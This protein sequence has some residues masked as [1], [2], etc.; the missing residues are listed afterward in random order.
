M[1]EYLTAVWNSYQ[2]SVDQLESYVDKMA[3]VGA[4]TATSL[5]EISTAMV[6]VASTANTVGVNMDQLTSIISTVASTTRQSATTIG[7]AFKT[8]FA[9][10]G[11]LKMGETLEDGLELGTVSSQLHDVGIEVLNVNG[12]LREMG[13]VVEEIGEKWQ[14]WTSAQQAAVAQAI[15]GKFWSFARLKSF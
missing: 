1:S 3:A 7:T 14:T 4:G 9:R 5:E 8:I 11:D 15:A 6:N 12:D 13:E 2:V 10:I